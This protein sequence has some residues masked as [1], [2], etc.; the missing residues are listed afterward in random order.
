MDTI[1]LKFGGSSLSDNEKL[2][3]VANK[4][5]DLYDKGH[6]IVVVLSAQGKTTDKLIYEAKQLSHTI[7]KREMDSLLSSGEQI[8]IAKLAILLKSMGYKAISLTGWQ[9][10][11]YTNNTNQD[12]IIEQI[13]ISRIKNELQQEKIVIIAGFQGMNEKMD[14]TTLGRG[15]SDTTALALAAALKAKNCYIFSDVDGVYTTDPK[16]V[17]EAKEQPEDLETSWK[18][19]VDEPEEEVPPEEISLELAAEEEEEQEEEEEVKDYK[20]VSDFNYDI[21]PRD[22]EVEEDEEEEEDD[23]DDDI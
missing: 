4:I 20:E 3:L 2:K 23:E 14:I 5:T 21:D 12:A 6:Q 10:G 22:F 16:K 7:D 13:D 8:S 19:F 9:A 17:K 18:A 1:V 11:I 15:G